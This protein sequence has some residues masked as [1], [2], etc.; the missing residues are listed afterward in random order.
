MTRL[1]RFSPV[2]GTHGGAKAGRM[3]RYFSPIRSS[4]ECF[5]PVFQ[6]QPRRRYLVEVFR[7]CPLARRSATGFDHVAR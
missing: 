6:Y 7:E 5:G 1:S 4:R 2:S 3:P